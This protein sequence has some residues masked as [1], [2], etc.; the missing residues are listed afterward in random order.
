MAASESNS[1]DPSAGPADV[2]LYGRANPRIKLKKT[3]TRTDSVC[4]DLYMAHPPSK[5][6]LLYGIF[7]V[8]RGY[9]A[10][11]ETR[12][13]CN[14]FYPCPVKFLVF[15]FSFVLCKNYRASLWRRPSAAETRR[16][17]SDSKSHRPPSILH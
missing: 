2:L 15:W 9:D 17:L 16:Q 10:M 6:N 3:K 5:C 12:Y 1:R 4:L 14:L 11:T 8:F 7:C 13:F